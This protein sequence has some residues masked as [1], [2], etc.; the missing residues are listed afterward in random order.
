M[1]NSR[2]ILDTNAPFLLKEFLNS[3]GLIV[4]QP[5]NMAGVNSK[6]AN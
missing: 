2:W 4:Q 5:K 6:T 1:L 3:K